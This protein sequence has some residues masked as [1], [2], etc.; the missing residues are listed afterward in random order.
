MQSAIK[1]FNSQAIRD[2]KS[3]MKLVP[4]IYKQKDSKRFSKREFK[5]INVPAK[6]TWKEIDQAISGILGKWPFFTDS[7]DE[8]NDIHLTV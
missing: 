8:N 7:L 4:Y 3:M 5:L 6:T 2:G 1:R